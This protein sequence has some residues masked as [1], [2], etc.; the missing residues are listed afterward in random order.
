MQ[1][2]EM[3]ALQTR[4]ILDSIQGYI[5]SCLNFTSERRRFH[6]KTGS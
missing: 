5:P 4:G 2:Q 3:E 6:E 1:N